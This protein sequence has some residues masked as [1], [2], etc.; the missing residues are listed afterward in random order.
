MLCPSCPSCPID[1]THRTGPAPLHCPAGGPGE[2]HALVPLP[3]ELV[4]G[5]CGVCHNRPPTLG[6]PCG[7]GVC[8]EC[9]SEE[10]IARPGHLPTS[11]GGGEGRE[12]EEKEGERE[13]DVAAR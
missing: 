5:T 9:A 4:D 13:S 2:G 8:E 3:A 12:E 7:V 1:P 10:R 11:H 6:C